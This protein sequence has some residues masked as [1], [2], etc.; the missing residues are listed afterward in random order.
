MAWLIVA[1]HVRPTAEYL[2]PG[3][4]RLGKVAA[5]STESSTGGS[6]RSPP[7]SGSIRRRRSCSGGRSRRSRRWRACRRAADPGAARCR[8]P[9]ADRCGQAAAARVR[10]GPLTT[11]LHGAEATLFHAGVIDVPPRKR[12]RTSPR[13]ARGSGRRSR[14]AGGD[15]AGL[16]RADARLAAARHDAA[17]E[18]TCASSPAG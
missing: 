14:P 5:G 16:H 11:R 1:G 15:T 12:P 3:N 4:L 2:V 10:G 13:C 18:R 7:G 17:V 8:E 9:A 6:C